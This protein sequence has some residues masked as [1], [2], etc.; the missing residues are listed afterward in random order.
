MF[1]Y[2]VNR[3]SAGEVAVLS[4]QTQNEFEATA[5]GRVI[6]RIPVPEKDQ[7]HFRGVM[8]TNHTARYREERLVMAAWQWARQNEMA[9]RGHDHV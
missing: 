9:V 8:T 5:R 3:G 4:D 6:G 7:A 2:I 1:F